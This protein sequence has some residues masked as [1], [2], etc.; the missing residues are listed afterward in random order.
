M[1]F[2]LQ[3]EVIAWEQEMNRKLF[4]PAERAQGYFCKF[5]LNALMRGDMKTRAEFYKALAEISAMTPNEIRE[6]EELNPISGL[7][8]P[9]MPTNWTLARNAGKTQ[10]NTP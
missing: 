4:T 2:T 1:I 9:Y 3:P 5:A 10:G 8:E 7:D 6:L